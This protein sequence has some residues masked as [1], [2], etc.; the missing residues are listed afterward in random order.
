MKKKLNYWCFIVLAF[1]FGGIGLQHF[2]LKQTVAGVFAALFCWTGI[3]TIVAAIQAAV[4]LFKG[5]DAFNVKYNYAT[6]TRLDD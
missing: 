3:P 5:E 1:T 6:K 2:Y 4:W